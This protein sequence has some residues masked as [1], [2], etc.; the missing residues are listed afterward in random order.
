MN[1]EQITELTRQEKAKLGTKEIAQY[2]RQQLKEQYP[3][4]S[5]SVR[6]QHFSGGS[7]IHLSLMKADF[8]VIKG[9]NDLSE[10]AVFFALT[11]GHR[12]EAQLKG[13]Q[14]DRYHQLNRYACRSDYNPDEWN[15]GVFLTEQGHNLLKSVVKI[16]DYYNYDESDISRDYSDTNF[17]LHLN[18]GDFEKPFIQ[19]EE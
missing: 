4:C 14:A 12:N 7:A 16:V 15:N 17:Y 6:T 18:I 10:E 5:F 3:N 8:K 19:K 11:R 2:I 1:A 9:F 13:I